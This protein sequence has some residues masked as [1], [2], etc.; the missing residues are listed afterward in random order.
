[1]F[2]PHMDLADRRHESAR[3]RWVQQQMEETMRRLPDDLEVLPSQLLVEQMECEAAQCRGNWESCPLLLLLL[4]LSQPG[5]LTA[6]CRRPH[7][8][9]AAAPVVRSL[10]DAS[11]PPRCHRVPE[12]VPANLGSSGGRVDLFTYLSWEVEKMLRCAALPACLC[13]PAYATVGL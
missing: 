10:A 12:L 5:P 2:L 3:D 4:W 13:R 6:H 8:E 9:A 7:R 11:M 1:M